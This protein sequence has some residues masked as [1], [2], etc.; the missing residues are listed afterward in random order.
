MNKL[1]IVGNGFDLAHGLP[2]S[3]KNFIDD[4]WKNAF[5]P[6]I[7]NIYS[8][9]IFIESPFREYV[10]ENN[11][12][13]NNFDNFYR[14]I[15][16]NDR[17]QGHKSNQA[18]NTY[19]NFK[20]LQVKIKPKFNLVFLF[21]NTFFEKI[22]SESCTNWV[23]IE[24]AYYLLLKTF[25]QNNSIQSVKK[26]NREFEQVKRVF[27]SYLNENIFRKYDFTRSSSENQLLN[28]FKYE[29]DWIGTKHIRDYLNEFNS[30]EDRQHI[31]NLQLDYKEYVKDTNKPFRLE[32]CFLNFNYTDTLNFYSRQLNGRRSY[33]EYW[34]E[35]S[36][37]QIHGKLNDKWNKINFGFGDENDK[38]YSMIEDLDDNEYL[39]YFKSFQYLQ[40]DN[41]DKLLRFIESEK[42]QV[43]IMGHSCGLSDRTLL[44]TIFEHE[45]CRSIKPFYYEWEE[46]DG[47]LRTKKD[48]YTELVQNI[49][50]HFSDKK[51]MRSK[52]V[53]KELCESL[54]QS[55]RFPKKQ[56][57]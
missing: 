37:I 41:Y 30:E 29:E 25:S 32:N 34:G 19:I 31:L 53:N 21:K 24:K 39:K 36:V 10:L 45:N 33:Y 42:F 54:P 28:H 51:V 23:D 8:D 14:L 18:N 17:L 2:T 4:F 48:N 46:E 15:K 40:N 56:N 50:R 38:D 12:K 7:E 16:S 57:S 11:S 47:E 20:T 44:S 9:L 52:L 13:C 35:T 3:Y 22:V 6:T 5:K 49:S 27:E 26:L 1:V 55:I 43:Y